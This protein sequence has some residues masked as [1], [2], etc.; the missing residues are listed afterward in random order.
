MLCFITMKKLLTILSLFLFLLVSSATATLAQ[1][2]GDPCPCTA[3]NTVCDAATN[4]CIGATGYVCTGLGAIPHDPGKLAGWILEKATLAAGG[5]ALVLLIY[6]GI[7]FI[8][9]QGDPEAVEEAKKTITAALT[10][11]LVIFFSI[12]ILRV[13]GY[14]I[15]R[16][17]GWGTGVGPPWQ[18]ILPQ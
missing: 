18:L 16:L 11:L 7:K 4:T 3:P 2:C 17:P 12:L 5:I 10:G 8:T 13:I 15:L 9:A 1:R 14:D 6:G